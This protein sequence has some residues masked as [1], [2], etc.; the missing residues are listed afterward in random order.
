MFDNLQIEI[1]EPGILPES[2]NFKHQFP[3]YN[4]RTL[5][6]SAAATS[7]LSVAWIQPEVQLHYCIRTE[8]YC[9]M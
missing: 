9:G 8:S 6:S 4:F 5:V 1:N 2:D 3:P 7:A